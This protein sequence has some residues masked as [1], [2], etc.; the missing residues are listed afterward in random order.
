MDFKILI[1]AR[2]GSKRILN[3][4]LALLK[5]RPLINYCLDT[6]LSL[7]PEVYVSTDCPKIKEVA[8]AAGAQVVDRPPRLA[9]DTSNVSETILHFLQLH[10]CTVLVLLQATSPLLK[11]PSIER[12][13]AKIRDCDSV[14]GTCKVFKFYWTRQHEP[15]NYTRGA[16]PRSQDVEPLYRENGA[17]Y[18][19]YSKNFLQTKELTNGTIQFVNM[20][21]RDSIDIDTEE[22]LAMAELMLNP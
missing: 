7:T 16:K 9:T 21:E 15:L 1:P 12:G 3:K 11:A 20:S 5:G 17:F 19:T 22:D 10:P 4:N 6:S 14:M 2:G 8:L 13:L 18:I